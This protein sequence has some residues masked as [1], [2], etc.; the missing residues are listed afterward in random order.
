MQLEG[1]YVGDLL[2]TVHIVN[3]SAA[4]DTVLSRPVGMNLFLVIDVINKP[5][6]YVFAKCHHL[7]F[8]DPSDTDHQ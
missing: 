6:L 7:G 8:K 4:Y 5:K 2:Y 1:S 3:N